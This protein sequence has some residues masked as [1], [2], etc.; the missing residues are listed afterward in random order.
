[1]VPGRFGEGWQLG[2]VGF[3]LNQNTSDNMY[4]A[5][6]DIGPQDHIGEVSISLAMSL[7]LDYSPKK[8]GCESGIIYVV[9]PGSDPGFK[10]WTDK[11]KIAIDVFD[12]WGGL[13]KLKSLSL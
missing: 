10:P 4:C 6:A 3:C 12:K 2:D 8:G 9:F 7:G 5:T 13:S 1:V 11:C